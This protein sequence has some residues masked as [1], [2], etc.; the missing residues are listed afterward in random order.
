MLR[1]GRAWET[2]DCVMIGGDGLEK[3]THIVGALARPLVR[4]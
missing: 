2:F 1:N 3:L 4:N